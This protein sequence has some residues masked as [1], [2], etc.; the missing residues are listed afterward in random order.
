MEGRNVSSRCGQR[1]QT[2]K[3]QD[4][5]PNLHA[6]VA[7]SISDVPTFPQS[8]TPPTAA[9]FLLDESPECFQYH[10]PACATR[11]PVS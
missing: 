6:S 2:R 10:L 3:V 5:T 1:L 8:V 11:S 4:Q 9:D 7:I